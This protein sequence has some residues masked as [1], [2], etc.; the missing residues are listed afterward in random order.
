MIDYGQFVEKY[1][2]MDPKLEDLLFDGTELRDGMIVLVGDSSFREEI[3]DGLRGYKLE[4][5]MER[6]RYC[7]IS[8][9]GR[10]FKNDQWNVVFLGEYVDGTKRK[11]VIAEDMPWIVV[12]QTM[13]IEHGM[14][15]TRDHLG[16]DDSELANPPINLEDPDKAVGTAQVS[17]N[18]AWATASSAFT[19]GDSD[20][21][22]DRM[23]TRVPGLLFDELYKKHQE[24]QTA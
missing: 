2:V 17:D 16:I 4:I 3:T 20:L 19:G 15:V 24:E 22:P 23:P 12:K 10:T 8:R 14:V 6:N 13:P 5:A 21:E 1:Y 7:K 18:R 9:V 11:V